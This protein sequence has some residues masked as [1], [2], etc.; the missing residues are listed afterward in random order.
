MSDQILYQYGANY[1]HLDGIKAALNDAEALRGDVQ[2]V[3]AL[4][5]DIYTGDAATALQTAQQ[6]VLQQMDQLILD[7]QATQ[8]Q[9]VDRQGETAALDARLAGGF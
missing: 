3:F 8:G 5:S 1:A 6:Q 2:K 4:L 7:M 9:A